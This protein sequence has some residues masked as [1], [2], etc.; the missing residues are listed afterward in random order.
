MHYLVTGGLGVVGS[1]YA[2]AKLSLGHRV[3]IIDAC[4]EPRNHYQA[5][6]LVASF[7]DLVTIHKARMESFDLKSLPRPDAI[8]HA[9]AYTGIPSSMGDP[10][11][12]W[13]SNVETTRNLLEYLR[14]SSNPSPTVV[15][16]SVKPYKL[17]HKEYFLDGSRY[18]LKF[19]V[20]ELCPLE[21]DEPYAAS[22]MAQSGICQA[23]ARTFDLPV[24]VFRCSNL[25][26]PGPCH[27]PRHGWLTWFCI[28]AALG[29]PI[30]VQGSGFQTRDMLYVSDVQSAVDL[31]LD[32]P[33]L[34]G[35]LFN[36]GGGEANAISVIQA[37]ERVKELAP[38]TRLLK[39]AGRKFEDSVFTTDFTKFRVLT[40]WFPQVSV[41]GGI[42]VTYQWALEN[43]LSIRELYKQCA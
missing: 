7:G 43:Q 4:E 33:T 39:A 35:Q 2:K 1:W 41:F 10:L 26:G 14:S 18:H 38:N 6:S 36:L 25:Y 21:P 32:D 12:D 23:Y 17:D 22:K 34:H 15:L 28:Q 27:G 29:L 24:T 31:A 16:S 3:T 5:K 37:A 40:G 30:E 20:D 8:L 9:A 11:D 13:V 19:P 42:E